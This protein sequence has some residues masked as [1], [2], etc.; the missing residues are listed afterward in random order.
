MRTMRITQ[1]LVID[2]DVLTYAIAEIVLANKLMNPAEKPYL[3]TEK[4]I[5]AEIRSRLTWHGAY[6]LDETWGESVGQSALLAAAE[7]VP[8]FAHMIDS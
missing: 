1:D 7:Y 3:V 4:N 2:E 5:L 8:Q 6:G